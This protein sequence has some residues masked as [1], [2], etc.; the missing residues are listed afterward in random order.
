MEDNNLNFEDQSL[1]RLEDHE[2]TVETIDNTPSNLLCY[3]ETMYYQTKLLKILDDANV[4]HD[5]YKKIIE[6]A[7]KAQTSNIKFSDLKKTR[8]GAIG[9]IIK[10]MPWL[11]STIPYIKEVLLETNGNAERMDVTVFN[12]ENQ[13]LNLLKDRTLF[14]DL[15]N[16]NVNP[17]NPFGKYKAKNNYL[18]TVNSG[19]RYQRAYKIDKIS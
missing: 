1:E 10:F 2:N 14:G 3:T 11:Q 9:E 13:L 19:N 7:I 8:D 6:W 15:Q 18:S 5:L 12:F 16:L 17:D 4:S